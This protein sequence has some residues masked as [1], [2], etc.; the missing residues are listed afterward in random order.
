MSQKAMIVSHN[1]EDEDSV[2]VGIE[3][4][5][6]EEGRDSGRVDKRVTVKEAAKYP[7]GMLVGV[8]VKLSHLT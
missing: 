7:V 6:D 4:V 2:R 1:R 5:Q 8:E 3:F